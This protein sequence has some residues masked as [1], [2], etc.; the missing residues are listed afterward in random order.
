[1][2]VPIRRGQLISVINDPQ[3]RGAYQKGCFIA[4]VT[5]PL[6]IGLSSIPCCF[7]SGSS[8]YSIPINLVAEKDDVM[9]KHMLALK[10]SVQKGLFHSSFTGQPSHVAEPAVNGMRMYDVPTGRSVNISPKHEDLYQD[11]V[12]MKYFHVI[13][14][15]NVIKAW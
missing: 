10:A 5:H 13:L 7:H 9:V 11:R 12:L 2:Y 1:M 8:F 6:Q 15:V 14:L 4:H 3:I